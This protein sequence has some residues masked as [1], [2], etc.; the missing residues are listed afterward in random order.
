MSRLEKALEIMN[1][2]QRWMV[3]YCILSGHSKFNQIKRDCREL[4]STT[5]ARTLKFLENN[6]IIAKKHDKLIKGQPEEYYL[7]KLGVEFAKV[8]GEMEA[9]GGKVIAYKATNKK[10]TEP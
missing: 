4:S 8:V 7:T 3:F 2:R 6:D 5:L 9:W 1:A 10:R